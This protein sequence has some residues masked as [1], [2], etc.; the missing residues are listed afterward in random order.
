LNG[1]ERARA[2]AISD[3][4]PREFSGATDGTFVHLCPPI[5]PGD[6]SSTQ[7]DPV[8][9][10]KRQGTSRSLRDN[11]SSEEIIQKP[12]VGDQNVE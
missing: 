12:R 10:L 8:G 5:G 4:V 3:E 7:E 6:C 11:Q 9:I 2:N 1:V